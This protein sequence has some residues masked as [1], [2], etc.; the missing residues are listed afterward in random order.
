M[1]QYRE[2]HNQILRSSGK[3]EHR[4]VDTNRIRKVPNY[5]YFDQ[6]R[7]SNVRCN[8]HQ[9]QWFNREHILEHLVTGWPNGQ[10]WA[11]ELEELNEWILSEKNFG[12]RCA[13]KKNKIMRYISN[14]IRKIIEQHGIFFNKKQQRWDKKEDQN[15][16]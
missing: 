3:E 4:K 10:K 15:D 12:I 11:M 5:G 14:K 7:Y 2:I 13:E 6:W 8:E 16:F 9:D 1:E